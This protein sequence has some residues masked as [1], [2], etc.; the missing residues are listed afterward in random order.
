MGTV[1]HNFS[2]IILGAVG[3]TRPSQ[4]ILWFV[5]SPCLPHQW[6][7][8]SQNQKPSMLAYLLLDML[9]ML[10]YQLLDMPLL[11]MPWP[12]LPPSLLPQLLQ[13]L[14]S[15][16]Q[17]HTLPLM[18]LDRT[19]SLSMYQN[20]LSPRKLNTVPGHMLLLTTL[21]SISHFLETSTLPSQLP[22]WEPPLKMLQS[23]VSAR[24]PSLSTS[25]C[26]LRNHTTSH[27]MSSRTLSKPLKYQPQSMLMPHTTYPS[28]PQYK[29]P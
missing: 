20:Q 16:S 27:M 19:P 1:T 4:C 17:L 24:N 14:P 25:Q 12:Q 11:H 22:F 15:L 8:L 18:S 10:A 21:L 23:P 3:D 7:P 13:P 2:C 9:L 5:C 26:Q 29:V 6:L 28:K